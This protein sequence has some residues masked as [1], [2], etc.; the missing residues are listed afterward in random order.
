VHLNKN[1]KLFFNRFL[2]PILML[3]LAYGVYR[4]LLQ[5]PFNLQAL[6]TYF[7]NG[8]YGYALVGVLLMPVNW[9]IESYKWKLLVK[10]LEPI[11]LFTAVKSI[12]S[13]VSISIYLPNRIGEFGGRIIQLPIGKRLQGIALSITASLSQLLATL[14]FGTTAL[15]IAHKNNWLTS[16]YNSNNS[17]LLQEILNYTGIIVVFIISLVY[18]R[19]PWLFTLLEKFKFL[20]KFVFALKDAEALTDKELFTTFLLSSFRYLVFLIQFVCMLKAFNVQIPIWQLCTLIS[21]YYLIMAVIP[22]ITMAELGIRGHVALGLLAGVQAGNEVGITL[23][24]TIIFIINI[25]V[26]ALLGSVFV[27]TIRWFKNETPS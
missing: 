21:T 14:I 19:I 22:S 26:P 16:F 12:L 5:K 11:S 27:A 2:G 8:G 15:W 4:Q 3:G 17:P 1:I 10:R 13:G 6:K 18:W 25:L 20:K 23:A 7:N 24:T 9:L